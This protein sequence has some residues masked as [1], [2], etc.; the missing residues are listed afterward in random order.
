[1][2]TGLLNGQ[3]RTLPLYLGK[4]FGERFSFLCP[5]IKHGLRFLHTLCKYAKI[6]KL[7][8]L[9]LG[10]RGLLS[11]LNTKKIEFENSSKNSSFGGYSFP[12]ISQCKKLR[13][14]GKYNTRKNAIK[15]RVPIE[16]ANRW[17]NFR[18]KSR[19]VVRSISSSLISAAYVLIRS[20]ST[21]EN[22]FVI[23]VCLYMQHIIFNVKLY[24]DVN[25][26]FLRFQLVCEG[27]LT[28]HKPG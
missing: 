15:T 18:E 11:T 26:R 14:N 25:Q 24:R 17:N 4:D 2:K 16:I 21:D 27:A 5:L 3:T 1:M 22:F 13:C 19:V 9:Y 7:S 6:V 12:L 20:R 10:R 23:Y 8:N 28:R